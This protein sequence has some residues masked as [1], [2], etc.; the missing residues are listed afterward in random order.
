MTS[1]AIRHFEPADLI[2]I[3]ALYAEWQAFA[4][5]LQLPY[6]S[7]AQ[8]QSKL[9]ASKD[10]FCCLIAHRDEEVLG[11][12]G[13]GVYQSPRRKHVATFGMGV[14]T[15]ARNQ[16]VGSALIAAAIDRCENWMNISRIEIE[17][18]TENTAAIALYQKHGFL[19]EGTCKQYAF[20]NGRYVD[21]HLMARIRSS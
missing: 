10:G 4:D 5:T 13:I 3:Q 20:R 19:I 21:A 17:V 7:Y 18:Y 6:Q 8:W 9:D 11:Q 15:A 2:Q 16:G 1:I 14:K 12:L